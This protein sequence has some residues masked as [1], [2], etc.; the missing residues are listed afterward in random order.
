MLTDDP[1]LPET[2][3]LI[4]CGFERTEA[5]LGAMDCHGPAAAETYQRAIINL[6]VASSRRKQEW[7]ESDIAHLVHLIGSPWPRLSQKA[8][9]VF[10]SLISLC[11]DQFCG[12]VDG[13]LEKTLSLDH[14]AQLITHCQEALLNAA[15]GGK[16][17]LLRAFRNRE[18]PPPP[19]GDVMAWLEDDEVHFCWVVNTPS[20][21]IYVAQLA[22]EAERFNGAWMELSPNRHVLLV[23]ARLEDRAHAVYHELDH[24]LGMRVSAC[25]TV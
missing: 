2:A 13:C 20:L 12:Y 16:S 4:R 9:T 14:Q 10:L 8:A 25:R 15:E 1:T 19:L 23:G 21:Q 18:A 17:N 5:P 3:R 24:I 11:H 6:F 7:S 22:S